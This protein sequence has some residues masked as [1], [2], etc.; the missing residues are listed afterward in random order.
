MNTHLK[1]TIPVLA[2]LVLGSMSA[3]AD[4]LGGSEPLPATPV[5]VSATDL[6]ATLAMDECAAAAGDLN[7]GPGD[8]LVAAEP[9]CECGDPEGGA[10]CRAT[11]S[12]CECGTRSDGTCYCRGAVEMALAALLQKGVDTGIS[13]T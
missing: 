10:G 5:Q 2:V 8:V 13:A 7:L 4:L 11:Q 6:M 12:P 1:A 3:N 9:C